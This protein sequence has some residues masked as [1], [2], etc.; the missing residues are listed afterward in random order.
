MGQQV[1]E[2]H[3]DEDEQTLLDFRKIGFFENIRRDGFSENNLQTE[4]L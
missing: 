4:K 2:L 1:P 3:S